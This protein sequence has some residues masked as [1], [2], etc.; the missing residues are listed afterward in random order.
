MNDQ[1]PAFVNEILSGVTPTEGEEI[2]ED[3]RLALTQPE[4]NKLWKKQISSDPSVENRNE[5]RDT[6]FPEYVGLPLSATVY[7]IH[8]QHVDPNM[9]Q[10]RMGS[11]I[12]EMTPWLFAK[13]SHM[14]Y[15]H[16]KSGIQPNGMQLHRTNNRY[17]WEP[18]PIDEY[19]DWLEGMNFY[20]NGGRTC[21]NGGPGLDPAVF[22][23]GAYEVRDL[24]ANPES[25]YR[26]PVI[27]ETG[28]Y[29]ASVGP[30]GAYQF[31]ANSL[32]FPMGSDIPTYIADQWGP[33]YYR[34][35][36]GMGGQLGRGAR[37]RNRRLNETAGSQEA[38][39]ESCWKRA[40]EFL[41]W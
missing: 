24:V 1:A 38:Y 5:W 7:F 34:A 11:A 30:G 22:D 41:P 31:G 33:A 4:I 2:R 8:P 13:P 23:G 19:I 28:V 32:F 3:P 21:W 14:I 40:V 26:Y 36:T 10:V 37:S 39:D 12:A 6:F 35:P 20:Q 16:G 27:C 15:V 17:S 25:D 18:V 9:P 29:F